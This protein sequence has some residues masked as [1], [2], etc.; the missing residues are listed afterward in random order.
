M[1]AARERL[2]AELAAA[3][4]EAPGDGWIAGQRVRYLVEA[5]RP[6]AAARVAAECRAERWWCE[7][8]AGY[9]LHA[10][11]DH[12]AAE[13]AFD[14]ALAAAPPAVR[15]AW[16]D[17]GTVLEP[18]ARSAYESL[19]PTAREPFARRVWWLA[20]PLFLVPGNERRAEHLARWTLDRMQEEA[21][22]AY[23]VRWGWDLEELLVRY[24][25]PAGWERTRERPLALARG[26]RPGVVAHD[27]P[28]GR[29]FLP[30]WEVLG[31]PTVVPPGAWTL[32]APRPRSR[33]AP[34]YARRFAALAHQLAV[35]DRGDSLVVVAG[36]TLEPDSLPAD[37]TVEGAV[38][39]S[40]GPGRP[41][42]AGRVVGVG[43]AGSAAVA[44]A[45]RP[46]VVGVE[47]L[48]ASAEVAGRARYG[49]PLPAR[50]RPAVSDLLLIEPGPPP[51]A[52]EEAIPRARGSE[53]V[54]PG[55]TVGL[56]FEIYPPPRGPREAR[57]A[58]GLRDER[59][60]F[61]RALGRAL[62]GGTERRTV[63]LEWEEPLPAGAAT[64]PRAVTIELPDLPAGD[65]AI[66]VE[67]RF[68][69]RTPVRA[70]RTIRVVE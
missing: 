28:G 53:A 3:A 13:V 55:E 58:V 31:G 34:G 69:G 4:G 11:G 60:G 27:P 46:A 18:R 47:A 64:V 61:L 66:V 9:A 39:V 45:R 14:A 32:D 5:G 10:A 24:G 25:W 26:R 52:L 20:D 35:F 1:V 30:P 54:G 29:P 50:S 41:H 65:Q 37:A 40:E 6:A 8:L 7:A 44:V 63:A 68:A 33:Y 36:W 15:D 48:A 51:A 38:V 49:L 43:P 23:G 22:S 17:L 21:L 19:G 16:N 59:G 57:I 2:L 56:F 70:E 67:V 12:A 62:G 42:R